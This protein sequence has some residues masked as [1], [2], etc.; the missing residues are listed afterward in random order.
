MEYT[1]LT[2]TGLDVSRICLGCSAFGSSSWADW[3]IEEDKSKKIISRARDL[4]INFFDT[5]NLYSYGESER[6]LGEA[7]DGDKGECVINSKVYFPADQGRNFEGLS[8]KSI[9]QNIERSRERLGVDTIDLYQIHRWDYQTPIDET[10]SALNSAVEN[11]KVNYIGASSIW[12]YQ[13]A[14]ANYICKNKNFEQFRT[15]Q[16]HYNLVYREE[17][18]EMIPFCQEEDIGILPWSPLA[19]GYLTRPDK[20]AAETNRGKTD[21]Y[22]KE[23]LDAYRKGGGIEINHRVQELADQKGVSMAQIS[24]A[25]LLHKE[26]IDAPIIGVTSIDHLESAAEALEIN[27]S[28]SDIKYLEE[29]Y[30]PIEVIGH[31]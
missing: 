21:E 10:L 7:L 6:I 17:E 31:E 8:R 2:G 1:T 14:K 3:T 18:R 4:G 30:E 16:N 15:L 23:R 20:E 11:E 28:E 26:W 9:R 13:L 25:W 22:L 12:A 27:L 5:A 24:I 29:P 19:R